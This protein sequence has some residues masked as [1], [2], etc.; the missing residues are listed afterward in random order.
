VRTFH[1]IAELRAHLRAARE[2]GLTIGFV[3]TMGAL[4]Q[5]HLS[6]IRRSCTDCDRTV[7]SVFVNPTQFAPHEDLAKYP[8]DLAAD[9]RLCQEEGVDALFVPSADDMYPP[10]ADTWVEVPGLSSRFEGA[11]R[12]GHFRGVAT[13]CTKLFQIV[14]P[15]RAYFGQK[16]Y[17]QLLVIQRMV[18]D[19]NMPITIVPGPT[20][21]EP[22]GLAMSSRN[23]YLGADERRS[24]TVLSRALFA[25]NRLFDEGERSADALRDAM[26]SVLAE[27]SSVTIDYAEIA[28]PHT[29]EPLVTITEGAVALGAIRVGGTRLIDNVL[30]GV[31][32]N[33]HVR[34]AA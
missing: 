16:D 9:S 14:Q 33:Q 6:L 26:R 19:L 11:L 18:A 4:H 3:P 21:R 15:H 29:L 1:Q 5:G 7:V 32:L 17:Q 34:R 25:A 20:V 10:E 30:L 24:A 27:E 28:H 12:P 23:V 22:D 8:R 2:E 31:T 13:V